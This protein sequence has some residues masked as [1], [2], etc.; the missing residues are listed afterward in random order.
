MKTGLPDRM[1]LSIVSFFQ[2]AK[3]SR[4]CLLILI[5]LLSLGL[6]G[7]A[8]KRL[9]VDFKGFE[10]AYAETSNRELLLNLARLQNRDPT[11]FFKIG[12]ITSAY[13]MATSLSGTGTYGISTSNATIG[14]PTGGGTP[15]MTFENDPIFT[16]IPVNDETNAQLLLKP[17]PAETFYILY[18]QGWRVDQLF[19]LMV[20]RIEINWSTKTGCRIQTVR[21]TP[22]PEF[23]SKNNYEN[24]K[25]TLSNYV[26]F[27]RISAVVYAL[28]KHGYLLLRGSKKFRAYGENSGLTT[29]PTAA[30]LISASAKNAIWEKDEKTNKWVLGEKVLNPVFCL[31]P[32]VKDTG[33]EDIEA[34]S[35]EKDNAR[36]CHSVGAADLDTI[37]NRILEDKSISELAEGDT[38]GNVLHVLNEGF[39]IA[40]VSDNQDEPE[41]QCKSSAGLSAESSHL[42]MRSLIGLMAAAAQEQVPFD[43][44][45]NSNP[46]IPPSP[47][48]P[49]DLQDPSRPRP[50]FKDAVPRVEQIP[51]LR[52]KP[53]A[54]D[55][56]R[57][58]FINVSYRNSFYSIPDISSTDVPE[59]Q[60][61]DRDMFRLISELTSQVTVDISKFPL[62]EILQ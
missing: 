4:M 30:D 14:G 18:E 62:T 23:S 29:P 13:K 59:N 20:D 15:S 40:G 45:A 17:V 55:R 9:R 35:P 2:S 33:P 47:D 51:L 44:L 43:A 57:K 38:L 37:R 36:A 6:S 1:T 34:A 11:Y 50:Q 32:P 3:R 58:S 41:G 26:T 19:R 21:N 42:V 39:S 56:D 52:L 25:A 8:A 22:P 10:N 61:W 54:G 12:Q 24:D 46:L 27:L 28:Q 60:Y 16:F 5:S 48:I 31:V 7:C 53:G 49:R